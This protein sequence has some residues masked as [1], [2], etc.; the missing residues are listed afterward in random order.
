MLVRD[1]SGRCQAHQREA[2][3]KKPT[4]AKRITGRKLQALRADLF[5]RQPLCVQCKERGLV[6]LATQRDHIVPLSEG[7]E[8]T[9]D[10]VQGLCAPCHDGKSLAERL[11]AQRHSRPQ[12]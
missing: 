10:N 9:E 7:G 8:D 11:R 12:G 4:A 5:R 3:G 6:A 2:W 1:G